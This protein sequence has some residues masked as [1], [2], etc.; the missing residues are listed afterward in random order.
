MYI[1][2]IILIIKAHIILL[3]LPVDMH[4]KYITGNY[5]LF[6]HENVFRII[7]KPHGIDI[8]YCI[9]E[10]STMNFIMV[11]IKLHNIV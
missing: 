2:I 10:L 8:I 11:R 1:Y 3:C 6:Y 4:I 9:I 7:P 5:F